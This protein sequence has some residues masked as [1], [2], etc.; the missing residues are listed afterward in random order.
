VRIAF[1]HSLQKARLWVKGLILCNR[2]PSVDIALLRLRPGSRGVAICREGPTTDSCAAIKPARATLAQAGAVTESGVPISHQV[3]LTAPWSMVQS[4]RAP[5]ADLDCWIAEYNEKR[6]HQ[7]A[8]CDNLA[9]DKKNV[10][11]TSTSDSRFT[12][13]SKR[14]DTRPAFCI[15]ARRERMRGRLTSSQSIRCR[16]SP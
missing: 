6:P 2:R 3:R 15:H 16:M 10:V 1:R 7:A 9:S 14:P 5:P 12:F 11:P 13:V 4:A 8:C